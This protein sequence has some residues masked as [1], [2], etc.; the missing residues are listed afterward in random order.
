MRFTSDIE[1][2][3]EI[4]RIALWWVDTPLL[5]Y[6]FKIPQLR[7]VTLKSVISLV[8]VRQMNKILRRGLLSL[9]SLFQKLIPLRL[10]HILPK[11]KSRVLKDAQLPLRFLRLKTLNWILRW[12]VSRWTFSELSDVFQLRL[13]LFFWAYY[14]VITWI[15]V[16]RHWIVGT[17]IKS[18]PRFLFVLLKIDCLIFLFYGAF[19]VYHSVFS[20]TFLGI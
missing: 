13:Q 15:F 12:P 18:V 6:L 20:L 2:R 10:L 19:C 3:K 14:F 4:W 5:S 9:G 11:M 16:L 8:D 17:L 7:V 1:V